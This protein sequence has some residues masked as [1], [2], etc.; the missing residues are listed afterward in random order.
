[1]HSSEISN[2]RFFPSKL[3]KNGRS[4]RFWHFTPQLQNDVLTQTAS[5]MALMLNG[6]KASVLWVR[7]PVRHRL[8]SASSV[9]FSNGFWLGT[10]WNPYTLILHVGKLKRK[11]LAL[12]CFSIVV[13]KHT[14]VNL[15]RR[16]F[17]LLTSPRSQF[18]RDGAKGKN[19]WQEPWAQTMGDSFLWTCSPAPCST[20]F[21]IQHKTTYPVVTLPTVGW[22]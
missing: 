20:Y 3:K 14:D 4:W 16:G 6:K 17:N 11:E 1:M 5:L 8:L 15:G 22:A 2:K 9:L 21:L 7:R 10:R 12:V 19:L 18:I 13:T